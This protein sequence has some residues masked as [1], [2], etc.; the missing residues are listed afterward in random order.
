VRELK[1]RSLLMSSW[2]PSICLAL[3]VSPACALDDLY[4]YDSFESGQ[5]D[6]SYWTVENSGTG[7]V[8]I[9][10]STARTGTYALQLTDNNRGEGLGHDFSTPFQGTISVWV[11]MQGTYSGWRSDAHGYL[12]V[13]APDNFN[14]TQVEF[15]FA[16]KVGGYSSGQSHGAVEIDLGS[17]AHFGPSWHEMKIQVDDTGSNAWFDDVLIP[18]H[19]PALTSVQHVH[20]GVG[21]TAYGQATFDDFRATR[22]PEPSTFALLVISAVGLVAYAWRRRRTR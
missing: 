15:E 6:S 7:T 18:I 1:L 17:V 5:I 13:W 9:T 12:G 3:L 8:A 21:W 22:V 4:H 20:F 14:E 11:S 10:T 16:D 2:L 19:N